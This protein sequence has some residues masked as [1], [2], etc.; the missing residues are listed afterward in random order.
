M[1]AEVLPNLGTLYTYVV[2]VVGEN[3]EVLRA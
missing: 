2:A 3:L 1:W